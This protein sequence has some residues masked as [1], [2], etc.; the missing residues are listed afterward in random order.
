[1]THSYHY[2]MFAGAIRGKKLK[3]GGVGMKNVGIFFGAEVS[4]G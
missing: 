1:V 2:T 3:K 4:K